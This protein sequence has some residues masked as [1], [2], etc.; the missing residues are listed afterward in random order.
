MPNT[1]SVVQVILILQLQAVLWGQVS[2]RSGAVRGVVLDPQG[3]PVQAAKIKATSLDTNQGRETEAN[4]RGEFLLANLNAGPYTL[5]V[6]AAGFAGKEYAELLVG[7]GQS[8]FQKVELRVAS[9]SEKMEV[10]EETPVLDVSA[11][12]ASSAFGYERMEH[13]SA[14]GRNYVN[15]VLT[16]PGMAP[17]QGQSTGRSPAASWNVNND[18]GFVS[19]G[20]RSRNNSV[21]IDGS[22]NR[23][24]TT[25]AMR[26]SVPLEM[27][28]ELRIAGTTVSAELGGAAGGVV[29]IVTRSGSNA[30]H[31]HAEFLFQNEALNARNPEFAISGRPRLRR[32]QPGA[33]GSGPLKKDKTFFA[34]AMEVYREDCDEWS[35]GWAGLRNPFVFRAGERNYQYSGKVQHIFNN[36]HSGSL[37]YAYSLGRVRDG[38]QGI[39]NRTDYSARGSSRVADH[40]VVGTLTSAFRATLLN[41][42]T[43]QYGRRGMDLT[44]N[45][46]EEFVEIPGVLSFGQS[47]KMDQQRSENHLEAVNGLTVIVGRNTI[48]VGG[49]LHRVGFDGRLANRFGGIAIYPTLGAY[50]AG[51]ADMRIRAMG[52]AGTA[53]STTPVGAWIN[54]RWQARRGLT[55][56]AG[57][58]YD[59]QFLPSVIPTTK[60]NVAPRFGLAWNPGGD[61]KTVFRL[62]TGL[63]FDRY[64][65]SY[66]N[67]AIQKDG[68]R[69]YEQFEY[70]GL[71]LR[72]RSGYRASATMPG[73]YGA[74]I[75][76]GV[77]RQLNA[78]TTL[79]VELSRVRGLHM[80]RIRNYLGTLPAQFLLEQ[81]ASSSYEG[82][83]VTLSRKM[84]SEFGYL[85][86]Y[87]GGRTRDD[88]SDFEE[89][90]QNPLN[91]RQEWALSRQHQAHRVTA[92]GLFEIEALEKMSEKLSHIHIVPSFTFGSGRPLPALESSDVFRTGAFPLSARAAG[93]GRNP[94]LTPANA[95]LDARVFKEMHWEDKHLRLQMGVEGY[96]LLNR[97]NATRLIGYVAGRQDVIEFSQARQLQLFLHFEF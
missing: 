91:L 8:L 74:K 81:N 87:T 71:N 92:T 95:S 4:E 47:W 94:F 32:W 36:V 89:Q 97:S 78:D 53:Y 73:T 79:R 28:Q 19:N 90:P 38:V 14:Q 43:F 1:S 26:V 61:S 10:V 93:L 11:T 55:I 30:M 49:S 12:T 6:E 20:I 62:G 85:I 13:S 84:T 51:L 83:N 76:A 42:F 82:V 66:L 46:R 67:E 60:T 2:S 15:F 22:D 45:S 59:Y 17:A 63:F 25:G 65:L 3:A 50:R 33:S 52:E 56:E 21:S 57:L 86:S 16:A 69:A 18:S 96:N 39:E 54:D 34:A 35:E 77:E 7:A 41:N 9:V 64:P 58:R 27:V 40:G 44:P 75:T 37:R 80:P 68:V 72:F 31:G 48:S 23:D 88:G 24:E 29:N 70:P 5:T